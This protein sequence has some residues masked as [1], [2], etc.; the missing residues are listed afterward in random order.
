MFKHYGHDPSLYEEKL[1]D[2][3]LESQKDKTDHLT[4]VYQDL[5]I[6]RPRIETKAKV[7]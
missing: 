3:L 7:V 6:G 2:Y 5:L 1:S 4:R